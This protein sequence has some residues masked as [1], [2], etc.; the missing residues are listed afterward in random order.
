M[1]RHSDIRLVIFDLLGREIAV[2]AEGKYTAGMYS[3]MLNATNLVSGVYPYQFE[4]GTKR[5]TRKL[6][7]IK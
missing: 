3:V 2:F 6:L 4:A 7:L 5:L 1:P